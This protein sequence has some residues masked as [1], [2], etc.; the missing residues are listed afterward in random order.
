MDWCEMPDPLER[1]YREMYS[2]LENAA[3]MRAEGPPSF[4]E[5]M[6]PFTSAFMATRAR[7][8]HEV[9]STSLSYLLERLRKALAEAGAILETWE[10]AESY[11]LPAVEEFE[12]DT[13]EIHVAETGKSALPQWRLPKA[14]REGPWTGEEAA[15]EPVMAECEEVEP[16]IRR[17]VELQYGQTR[18]LGIG[19]SQR[20]PIMMLFKGDAY[21]R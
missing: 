9:S 19:F 5:I 17:Q 15:T 11:E 7:Y 21:D 16:I 13:F 14:P 4:E 8:G 20:E 18:W 6:M 3:H 2:I 1:Q 10:L 12:R